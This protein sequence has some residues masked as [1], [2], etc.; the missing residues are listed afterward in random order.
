MRQEEKG[1]EQSPEGLR[2]FH[3][4]GAVAISGA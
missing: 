4:E 3:A 2:S 1:R